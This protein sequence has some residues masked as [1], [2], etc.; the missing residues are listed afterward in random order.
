MHALTCRGV[1]ARL[2]ALPAV[3]GEVGAAIYRVLAVPFS[4]ASLAI[5]THFC[6]FVP[7]ALCALAQQPFPLPLGKSR[8]RLAYSPQSRRSSIYD[9]VL[10]HTLPTS[11]SAS[12]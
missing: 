7:W 12:R 1:A 10:C 9:Q 5:R 2:L 11:V 3:C 4:M 6:V 8:A